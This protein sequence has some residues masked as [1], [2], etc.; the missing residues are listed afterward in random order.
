[1]NKRI[2]SLLVAF[3]MLFVSLSGMAASVIEPTAVPE[4]A[5]ISEYFPDPVVALAVANS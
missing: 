5:K 3:A 1:M 2:M 4:Q